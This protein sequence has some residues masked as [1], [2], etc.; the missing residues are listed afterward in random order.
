MLCQKELAAFAGR[1][2]GRCRRR[3]H[4]GSA[5]VRRRRGGGRQDADDPVRQHPRNRRLVGRGQG[6]N[7]QDRRAARA[8][9]IART[10][11]SAARR[12]SLRGPPPDR[13]SGR[14]VAAVGEARCPPTSASLSSSRAAR[15]ARAS[16]AA[17]LSRLLGPRRARSPAGSARSM[18]HGRRKIRST[19]IFARAAM[20]A[21][22][23]VP[24]TRSISPTRSTSSAASRIASA[25]PPAARRPRSISRGATSP[26]SE[27]FDL[28]LDLERTPHFAMHQPPQG[29]LAPGADADGASRGGDGNRDDDGR[30]REAQVFR[31]QGRRSARTAGRGNP[32][33]TSASTSARRRPSSPTA[34]TS[35]SSRIFAW[36]AAPARPCARRAR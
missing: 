4:A 23:R 33:A 13:R 34:I 16:G 27:R 15:A 3:L 32:A 21:C 19:S 30:I 26:R 14:G 10:G 36:A 24:R 8:C 35:R 11:A 22:T 29:Y 28:V 12:L 9:R 7:A 20:R 31:V 18:S 25:S 2:G 1:C 5:A 6:R 17:R